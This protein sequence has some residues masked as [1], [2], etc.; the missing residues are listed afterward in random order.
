M[1]AQFGGDV[2]GMTAGT[3]AVAMCESGIEYG[4]LSI[5]TNLAAGFSYQ[6]L[7]HEDVEHEMGRSAFQA[8]DIMR[9]AISL[10]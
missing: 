3:E 8:W 5:V 2:I 9:E 10:L 1:F 7:S 4:L 6:P